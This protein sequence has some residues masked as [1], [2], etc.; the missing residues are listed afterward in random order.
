M[1]SIIWR[2]RANNTNVFNHEEY[3]EMKKQKK[4][5]QWQNEN[6]ASSTERIKSGEISI[7]EVKILSMIIYPRE[8]KKETL[9]FSSAFSNIKSLRTILIIYL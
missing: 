1:V 4:K 3:V 7:S 2:G 9:P 5:F 6:E 8:R